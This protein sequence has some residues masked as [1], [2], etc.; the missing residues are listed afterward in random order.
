[1]GQKSFYKLVDKFYGGTVRDDKSRIVGAA[2]NLEEIDIFTNAN[3]IQ[4]EQ[5][6]VADSMPASTA[7]YAK[8]AGDND[9]TYGY[10]KK[11]TDGAVRIVSVASGGT[12]NPGAF[13]TLVTSA[14]TTN[15]ATIVSDF[16]FFRTTEASNPTSLYYIAGASATWYFRR[17]N[18][19]AAAEQI[20]NG[21]A[22]AAGT[23]HA[24]SQLTG[25]D[26]SFMRPTMKV[27]FG[28]LYTCQGRY[29]AK[30]AK[31]GTFTE[32]AFT[33]PSEW[34]AVDI[35]PVGDAAIV[36]C[37]NKTRLTNETRGYWWDLTSTSQFEDQFSIPMGGPCWI[38]NVKETVTIMCAINTVAKFFRLSAAAKGAVPLEIPGVTFLSVGADASTQPISSPKMLSTKDKVIYFSFNKTDK[39]GIYALGQLDADKPVAIFLSKR[40]GTTDYALHVPYS[41]H[42]QGPNFYADF[43]DNGTDTSVRCESNNTPD[44]SVTGTY[45]SIWLD[46]DEPFK[47]K[48]LLYVL[49]SIYPLPASSSVTISIAVDYSSTYV[50]LARA[51]GTV[52]NTTN[53]VF[54][55]CSGNVGSNKKVF[56]IKAVLASNTSNSPKLT[57]LGFVGTIHDE[58]ASL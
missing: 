6:V 19:G 17:Y 25:L 8:T 35:E 21:T 24:S 30:V 26:G 20:W 39:S 15:L 45:E 36:L 56:R 55:R 53:A 41:L 28:D 54:G 57:A 52:V 13:S 29:I 42:I 12:D 50:S 10:G 34:E 48:N 16:K 44:R 43:A 37:R 4:A 23:S 14:D 49:A 3:F 22:W 18:I 11:T 47:D 33:L 38:K 7:I 5:I 1:M 9:T 2:S 58:H 27:I 32:K 31:D 40:F 51:D 46:V